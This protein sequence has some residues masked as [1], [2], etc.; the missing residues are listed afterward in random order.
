MPRP[1][2]LLLATLT[3]IHAPAWGQVLPRCR[4]VGP[5]GAIEL[6]ADEPVIVHVFRPSDAADMPFLEQLLTLQAEG[7]PFPFR[8]I[9]AAVTITPD[10]K[11]PALE[12]RLDPLVYDVGGETFKLPFQLPRFTTVIVD[13][14]GFVTRIGHPRHWGYMGRLWTT[15]ESLQASMRDHSGLVIELKRG[16]DVP[17]GQDSLAAGAGAGEAPPPTSA[18][19]WI[20]LLVAPFPLALLIALGLGRRWRSESRRR[21][22]SV[23][24]LQP[25][26]RCAG[27][28]VALERDHVLVACPACMTVVHRACRERAG[29]CPTVGC[30][31]SVRSDRFAPGGHA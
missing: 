18:S 23:L 11:H 25:G 8:Q 30:S 31:Q 5:G 9:Y 24:E 12:R 21:L 27:C 4:L 6:P 22:G 17:S 15:A 3:L 13:P 1:L 10:E 14:R 20:W 7:K 2:W 19:G 28:A 16:P 26:L 29:G